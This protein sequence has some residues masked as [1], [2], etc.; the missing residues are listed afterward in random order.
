M[1]AVFA[2]GLKPLSILSVVLLTGAFA[3]ALDRWI[4]QLPPV[5]I[6]GHEFDLFQ[7]G[8]L[9]LTRFNVL[10]WHVNS[11]KSYFVFGAIVFGLAALLVTWLRRSDFSHHSLR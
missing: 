10:G 7:S 8:S 9:S 3:V 4:F 1:N 2:R 6:I 5:R 11:S